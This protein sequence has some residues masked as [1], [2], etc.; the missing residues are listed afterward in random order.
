M[1]KVEISFTDEEMEILTNALLSVKQNISG[2]L[3]RDVEA[4]ELILAEGRQD[5][6]AS[7]CRYWHERGSR[8]SQAVSP[9]EPACRLKLNPDECYCCK[10]YKPEE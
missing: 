5:L 1:D 7:T 4:V 8:G 3:E 2:L 10:K 6:R 9:P